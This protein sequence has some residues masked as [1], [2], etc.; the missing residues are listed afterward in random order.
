[1]TTEREFTQQVVDLARMFGFEHVHFRPAK[2]AHGWRTPVEGS[3]GE[4]WPDWIL[5]RERDRRLIFAELKGDG[6]K[7]SPAQERVLEILRSLD[8]GIR[9]VN[10]A[11]VE[12]FVWH[13]SDLEQIAEVL[14]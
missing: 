3:M 1:M 5:V 12:V 11:R 13:P 8:T 7:V 4:G 9:P 2:T 10:S 14:R 6:G